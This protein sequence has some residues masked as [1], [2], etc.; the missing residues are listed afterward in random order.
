MLTGSEL[1]LKSLVDEGVS[2]IFGHPGGAIMPAYEALRKYPLRHVLCRHEQT[3]AHAAEGYYK[4]SGRPGTV[5]VTS[6]PGATNTITGLTDALMDSMAMVVL[7]G[8]VPTAVMG[9]DAFQEA[10]VVGTSRS[11]TKHN[12]LVT[13]TGAI[14]E[15]IRRS[16]YL[17]GSGRP[18]PVLVDLPKDILMAKA[19]YKR[20]PE[21]LEMR[22]YKPQLVGNPRQIKRAA[23][24]I[25][26]AKRPVIYGGGGIIHSGASAE[27]QQLAA[28]IQSPVTLTLMGLGAFPTA[29]PSWLG[30]LGMH[31]TYY[32]NMAMTH[33]D[34]MIAIGARF[35][36]RVTGRLN[37]FGTQ[38]EIVHIDID[39][40]SIRKNVPVDVP[41]VGDVKRVLTELQV[42]LT[43]MGVDWSEG[44][45]AWFEQIDHW[46]KTHPLRWKA[47][48]GV[49]KPQEAINAIITQTEDVN[50]FLA[51]GV[52][53]HQMWAAQYYRASKPRRWITSGG[54]GTMGFGLPAALGAQAAM[55]DDLCLLIDGDG[56]F[57]M[58]P[59]ELI[60]LVQYQLPVKTFI[61]N[62]QYLG[63][64]RQWQEL[65]YDRNYSEVDLSAQPDFVKLAEAYGVTGMR[66]QDPKDL[67]AVVDKAI[68]T[69]GPVVVDVR[70]A[71][72][73][74]CFPIIPAGC[75]LS[76]I[77]DVDEPIPD[78]LF[79]GIR[80]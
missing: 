2:T 19:E 55:P 35:D 57:Q 31:G 40:T 38:C 1:L 58:S 66:V 43:N 12:Y 68:A 21:V 3:A 56:S 26:K 48:E 11:C 72:E 73:E 52:G 63:M 4:A 64:V 62:N 8:Q 30:M 16:Y 76:E 24:L 70:V 34:V 27:L 53:Q 36:D 74:N 20:G 23:E 78:E 41:I 60:T 42:E 14:P 54:L 39:P 7:S 47:K 65:F 33:C 6:G 79:V 77:I 32:A 44:R 18:G 80:S 46:R 5:M 25:A 59:Q 50:P 49:I 61:I 75:S 51:T 45:Q 69:P 37:D 13:D 29:H 10:D 9:C 15:T 71:R 28:L 67:S 17:A 22:G